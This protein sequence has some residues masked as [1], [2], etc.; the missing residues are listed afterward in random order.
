MCEAHA[1]ISWYVPIDSTVGYTL[2]SF[3]FTCDGVSGREGGTLSGSRSAT[4]WFLERSG[5]A[6]S[7]VADGTEFSVVFSDIVE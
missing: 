4:A 5:M 1:Y 6:V 2:P 7:S 3:S